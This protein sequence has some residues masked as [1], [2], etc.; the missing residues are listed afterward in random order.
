MHAWYKNKKTLV[1]GT[2]RN[3]TTV[4]SIYR[5]DAAAVVSTNK[6]RNYYGFAAFIVFD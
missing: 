4:T 1:A 3:T 6:Q 2:I 5:M